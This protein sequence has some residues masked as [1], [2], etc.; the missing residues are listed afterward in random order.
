[1]N[2]P[3]KVAPSSS[4]SRCTY[5]KF[6]QKEKLRCRFC[7]GDNCIRCGKDAYK[8]CNDPVITRFHC[9]WIFDS[10]L[11]MQR[12]SDELFDSIMLIEAF[13]CNGITAVI[14]LCEPGEHPYCGYPLKNSGFPY[15]PE[16]LMNA[17]IKYFNFYWQDMTVPSLSLAQNTIRVALTEILKGGKVAVHCHAGYGRTGI[18]V[19]CL[20]L[21]LENLTAKEAVALV[22]KK[23][24]GS[25]QTSA[26]Q[27]FVSTFYD[28]YHRQICVYPPDNEENNLKALADSM[29]DELLSPPLHVVTTTEDYL[30]L[31]KEHLP[32]AVR[33]STMILKYLSPHLGKVGLSLALAR[34]TLS[35]VSIDR[36]ISLS[37]IHNS[38]VDKIAISPVKGFI[39]DNK[40]QP[41][42]SG[43]LVFE[44]S[45]DYISRYKSFA[46][47]GKWK[48]WFS[49]PVENSD[50]AETVNVSS[51]E[52]GLAPLHLNDED[53]D[54][55]HIDVQK[56]LLPFVPSNSTVD[57]IPST[58]S[59]P[60]KT[61]P[62][63]NCNAN[64]TIDSTIDD[65]AQAAPELIT[66]LACHG[67]LLFDWFDSRS[68]AMFTSPLLEAL[69][70]LRM[71]DYGPYYF[72]KRDVIP[73]ASTPMFA[74][75]RSTNE[76]DYSEREC[77]W[78][79]DELFSCTLDAALRFHLSKRKLL[80]LEAVVAVLSPLF[81]EEERMENAALSSTSELNTS[82]NVQSQSEVSIFLV[83]AEMRVAMSMC[84]NFKDLPKLLVGENN[85]IDRE[86]VENL[87]G[88]LFLS[89]DTNAMSR[90]AVDSKPD[91]STTAPL[92]SDSKSFPT[93]DDF[94]SI[95]DLI[96]VT[97]ALRFLCVNKWS[98]LGDTFIACTTVGS[99]ST[100]QRSMLNTRQ[101]NVHWNE[102]WID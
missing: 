23:R 16:R 25:V 90:G 24:P 74:T 65:G 101:N 70:G 12:P 29:D 53:Y 58:L 82:L 94:E 18:V 9:N 67:S 36:S 80:L 88:R 91:V 72:T 14:N 2:S 100:L 30:L 81:A 54:E 33:L 93:R 60:L 43:A 5:R 96:N 40:V 8:H 71:G 102:E 38:S 42:S 19:A 27:S 28:A 3:S 64:G 34:L 32:N 69:R 47:T 39:R 7:R 83:C 75:Q 31:T 95:D 55:Q 97:N 85:G 98:A 17:G 62:K 6:D 49:L 26:Q 57:A 68:D 92:S 21:I 52:V 48:K 1:M 99:P 35:K 87:F 45:N 37:A 89:Y 22:R 73:P 46:N 50:S 10:V 44:A 13:Q 66:F 56:L 59:D 15:S 63:M 84:Q 41:D 77:Q 76:L 61:P 79:D 78:D 11:A 86:E 20:A 51:E 4:P